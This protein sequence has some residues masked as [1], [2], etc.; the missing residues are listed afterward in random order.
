MPSARRDLN[1]LPESV[2]AAVMET[3]VRLAVEPRRMGKPL[4]WE[5]EGLWSARRGTYRV[6]YRLNE[7][8]AVVQVVAIDHRANVYRRGTSRS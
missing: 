5:L 2:A 4:R 6:I 8:D 1:R 3:L 7:T